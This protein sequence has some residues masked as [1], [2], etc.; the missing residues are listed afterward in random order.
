MHCYNLLHIDLHRSYCIERL[1]RSGPFD[2]GPPGFALHLYSNRKRVDLDVFPWPHPFL[3]TNHNHNHPLNLKSLYRIAWH[4]I[5]PEH[6]FPAF[7]ATFISQ[8]AKSL[9]SRPGVGVSDVLVNNSNRW[10]LPL[11]CQVDCMVSSSSFIN[12]TSPD[13]FTP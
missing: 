1:I 10:S 5:V 8:N 6:V 4:N 2:C 12:P 7:P 11:F 3:G 9:V 13:K